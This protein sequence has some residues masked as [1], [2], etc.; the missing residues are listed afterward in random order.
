MLNRAALALALL[1]SALTACGDGAA[2]TAN[3][4]VAPD[5][6]GADTLDADGAEPTDTT[7]TTDAAEVDADA[8]TIDADAVATDAIA[9]CSYLD[10]RML[11][12]C[13]G[14]WTSVLFWSDW[15]DP[16]C[17]TWW[18]IGP[19][20]FETTA[21]LAAD[22]SCEVDCV[23]RA[24]TAVDFVDCDGHRNGYEVYEGPEG[25]E[26]AY[27]TSGGIFTDLCLWPAQT[28]YCEQR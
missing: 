1:L 2:G 6:G 28:C 24:T 22:F 27:G 7:D 13:H 17:P 12:K 15:G 3:D 4:T 9:H 26:V 25:C 14:V 21:D 10:D 11:V 23:L 20:R 19:D 16:S 18:Q 5:T 8:A